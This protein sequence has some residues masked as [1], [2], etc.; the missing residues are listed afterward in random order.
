MTLYEYRAM[1]VSGNKIRGKLNAAN[2]KDL[3][4]ILR[5]NNY[6]PFRIEVCNKS[7]AKNVILNKR[8]T[9]KD[10]SIFCRQFSVL[11][12]SGIGIINALKIVKDETQNTNFCK[13]IENVINNIVKGDSLSD[14]FKNHKEI[15]SM[16]LSM[17]KIGEASGRLDD[18][19]TQMT[20]YYDREYRMEQKIKQA[21]TY[22]IVVGI[23]SLIVLNVLI[24]KV[25]P[26]FENLFSQFEGVV[27]PLPTRIIVYISD[28]VRDNSII[29]ILCFI[30]MYMIIKVLLSTQSLKNLLDV[31]KL[32]APG[33]GIIY[34]K[35]IASRFARTLGILT[36]SGISI[37][38][39]LLICSDTIQ[40]NAIGSAIMNVLEDIKTGSGIADSLNSK[41]IFPELFVQMIKT[42]EESGNIDFILDKCAEFYE[43]E[44]ETETIK[45]VSL[46][47]PCLIIV[48][49]IVIG[50]IVLSIILPIF[51][52]YQFIR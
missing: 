29:I 5:N 37:I 7:Y 6:Y 22:P 19:L 27:L 31:V 46:L 30:L 42:G 21:L 25:I 50:F 3:I 11:I 38:D 4:A 51:N 10:L 40:N 9:L 47:E 18:I 52:M 33:Y 1:S 8:I 24:L 39:G 12:S 20:C 45:L 16:L 17:I 2:E 49:S 13:I 36:S 23:F 44:I 43:G 26:S 32:K 48:L 15:P 34:K 14:A 41:E 28:Y 35:I